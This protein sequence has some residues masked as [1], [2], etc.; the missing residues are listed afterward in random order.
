MIFLENYSLSYLR[1]AV[2]GG[3]DG[4]GGSLVWVILL[5]ILLCGGWNG[6]WGN[7]QGDKGQLCPLACLGS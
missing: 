3:N 1:A 7:R 4:F 5:F 6:G 2:D